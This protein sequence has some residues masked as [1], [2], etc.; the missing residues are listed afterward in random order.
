MRDSLGQRFDYVFGPEQTESEQAQMRAHHAGIGVPVAV[1][2]IEKT[3]LGGALQLLIHDPDP[4]SP[5]F[6]LVHYG[7]IIVKIDGAPVDGMPMGVAMKKFVGAPGTGMTITVQRKDAQG[8]AQSVDVPLTRNYT[9]D[10]LWP[11]PAK[12]DTTP[13]VPMEVTNRDQIK[14]AAGF[15]MLAHTPTTG[16]PAVGKVK[17][18]DLLIKV[19]GKD[20]T[21]LTLKQAV[22]LVRGPEGSSV[23]L[24]VLRAGQPVDIAITRG[25]VEEHAVHFKALSDNVSYIRLDQFSA[26]NVPVDMLAALARAVVPLASKVLTAQGDAASLALASRFNALTTALEQGDGFDRTTLPIL[27]K[28]VQ[29]YEAIGQGG[30]IVLDLRS[31]PGGSLDVLK[32]LAAMMLPQGSLLVQQ[33]RMPGSDLILIHEDTLLPNFL[34]QAERPD[35]PEPSLARMEIQE[36]PRMPLIVPSNMALTVLVD[37]ES[38]SAA[39]L[40]SGMLQANHRAV[41]I[42]NS[43][44]GKGVGQQLIDLPYG[45][46]LHVTTFEFFPAG[47]KS[48]WRGVIVDQNVNPADD[49]KSDPQLD[50]AVAQVKLE[51]KKQADRASAVAAALALH[52]QYF[53]NEIKGRADEDNK[54]AATQDPTK[55]Q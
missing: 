32:K 15:E 17:E 47:M 16:S 24:T 53:D 37:G 42:G 30:G 38:A 3:P 21:G 35:D 36:E 6:G 54:P 19:D 44:I 51:V 2:N 28:A 33:E 20:L 39:E 9:P 1:N 41:I 29:V 22:D 48:D 45:M 12:G 13:G 5:A 49:G 10:V 52:H 34:V 18:G 43:T 23:T 4:N 7:D 11:L 31:N 55:K 27:Q 46:S 40:L 14:L 8:A 50:A 26:Q 25:T